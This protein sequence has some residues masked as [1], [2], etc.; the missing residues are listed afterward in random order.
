MSAL[1]SLIATSGEAPLLDAL[2]FSLPPS[3]TAVVDR[4]QHV[5]AYPTSA[6][7]PTPAG[8]RTVRIRLG[9]DDFID[10]SS[11]RLQYTVRNLD[12]TNPMSPQTGPWGMWSQVYLRSG[13]VELDN[14]PQYGRFHHQYGWNHLSQLE[15][16]GEAGI[17]GFA[18]SWATGNVQSNS[19]EFGGINANGSYTVMHKLLLSIFRPRNCFLGAIC[20][21]NWSAR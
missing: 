16:F 3:S 12:G 18:G 7:S 8:T 10:P 5:K 6:S 4:R 1:E 15:Q 11:I 13:G 2:D 17:S 20:R 19:P 9:G 14:I 21:W